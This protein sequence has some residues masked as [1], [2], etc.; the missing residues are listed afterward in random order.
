[1][2]VLGQVFEHLLSLHVS[3]GL[4][5][6]EIQRLTVVR[7]RVISHFYVISVAYD[8]WNMSAVRYSFL[9]M[10]QI[11]H[12]LELRLDICIKSESRTYL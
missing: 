8:V 2:S 3:H 5:S 9:S 4:L 12:S 1:M 10:R 6:G 11:G 7:G